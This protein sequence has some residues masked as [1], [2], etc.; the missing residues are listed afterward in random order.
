M[1]RIILL[2]EATANR[3]AAGEVVERPA[4]VVKELVENS[5]DA[6]A[7]KVT[8]EMRGGGLEE[9][10]VVD[11][12]C[13][14]DET[15]SGAAFRRHATSKISSIEDLE[16]ICSL[17]FRG[18]AL[19]SIAAVSK[20]VLT[21]R[22]QE[23]VSGT[24][25]EIHGGRILSVTPAGCP[26]GTSITVRELFYNTPARLK[27]MKS[28][29]TEA[30]H[31]GDIVS[32]LALAR[33]DVAVGLS[34]DGKTSLRAPGTGSLPDAL[35]AV[36]GADTAREMLKLESSDG[37]ISVAGLIAPPSASR[38]SKRHISTIVNGRYIRSRLISAAV[39]DGYGSL[40]PRGRYPL[41]VVVLSVSPQL[42]DVN[43]HPSKMVI[44][45][46]GEE[47]IYHLIKGA[48][49]GALR[50]DRL[51]PSYAPPYVL[52]PA[53][54]PEAAEHKNGP[55]P[56]NPGIADADFPGSLY[57]LSG[58][59]GDGMA[60]EASAGYPAPEKRAGLLENALPIG[61]LPP[62]YIL[63]ASGEDLLIIDHHAAHERILYERFLDL[64]GSER[65]ESQ[66]L[67]V[68][69]VIQLSPREYQAAGE[70]LELLAGIGIDA[71]VFGSG[72]LLV[73]EVPAG[74]PG[75]AVGDLLRDL[76]EN[77]TEPGKKV[78]RG[79]LVRK[80]A[81]SAACRAAVKSGDKTAIE[82]AMAIVEDLKKTGSPYTCPHGRPTVI[83]V[84]GRELKGRFKRT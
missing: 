27:H 50:T 74:L 39:I 25:L 84:T 3:I 73:R 43:V 8:V 45:I 31:A 62:A 64:F 81:T 2:D 34:I 79:D 51:I 71:A 29:G 56:A 36:Y 23:A 7:S 20:T 83:S 61:F 32:R 30:G 52:A 58:P 5:L 49:T 46:S 78:T 65:V 22:P 12:G 47:K 10:R 76:L 44:K 63:A 35:V 41:A 18:E 37:D 59:S 15:D 14:M 75:G 9:I 72:S 28:T 80:I 11:D 66:I 69:A 54:S 67:L 40:I 77:L 26:P 13:G 1:P 82:E 21:T 33:P 68:P 48:V 55:G 19:P 24:R 57:P 60:G 42:L 16:E 4:S 6:G 38:N 70:N 53:S 17:G